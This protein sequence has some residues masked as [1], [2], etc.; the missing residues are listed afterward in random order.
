MF[1]SRWKGTEAAEGMMK[2]ASA[3]TLT[4]PERSLNSAVPP[5]ALS[6]E[7]KGRGGTEEVPDPHMETLWWPSRDRK[8]EVWPLTSLERGGGILLHRNT[9]LCPVTTS[10][11][12][13]DQIRDSNRKTQLFM[14]LLSDSSKKYS[15][16][17]MGSPQHTQVKPVCVSVCVC[18]YAVVPARRAGCLAC[19]AGFL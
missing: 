6:P 5:R 1:L 17:G 15:I 2:L 11:G 8:Q 10:P 14:S 3:N 13:V 12:C 4:G 16:Q 18:L 7:T 9:W 19:A